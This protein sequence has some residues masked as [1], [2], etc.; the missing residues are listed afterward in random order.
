MGTKT[1][2]LHCLTAWGQWAVLRLQYTAS[3]PGGSGQ[4]KSNNKRSQCLGAVGSETPAIH[5]LIAWGQWA[6]GLLRC[7][8]SVSWGSG[9]WNSRN[10]VPHC[11]GAV[12]RW[13]PAMQCLTAWGRGRWKSCN[14]LPHCLGACNY[15]D[16]EVSLKRSKLRQTEAKLE[17]PTY[18]PPPSFTPF[19]HCFLN[20]NQASSLWIHPKRCRHHPTTLCFVSGR[21]PFTPQSKRGLS[22]SL[23]H[24][25]AR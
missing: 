25:G 24:F 10:K 21:S 12:G 4:W 15:E 2:A 13:N 18:C 1:L 11:L 9:Q 8:V 6:V 19:P 22:L 7:N 5:C 3:L 17:N 16:T 23:P 20:K 14:A